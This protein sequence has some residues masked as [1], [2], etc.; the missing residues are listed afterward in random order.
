MRIILY[1][2]LYIVEYFF[3]L[4]DQVLETS[5]YLASETVDSESIINF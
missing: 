4:D 1:A 3:F 2:S 5:V